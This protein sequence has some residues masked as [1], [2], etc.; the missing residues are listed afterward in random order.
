MGWAIPAKRHAFGIMRVFA[1]LR[2]AKA[3]TPRD[4]GTAKQVPSMAAAGGSSQALR[5]VSLE[6]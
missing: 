2:V 4:L 6:R 5:G 3:S 1:L